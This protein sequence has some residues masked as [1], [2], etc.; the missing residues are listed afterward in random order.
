MKTIT[1]ITI[2][3]VLLSLS[4]DFEQA[5]NFKYRKLETGD[6]LKV[7]GAEPLVTPQLDSLHLSCL[8]K[9]FGENDSGVY[10]STFGRQKLE[11]ETEAHDGI[12]FESDSVTESAGTDGVIKLVEKGVL[13]VDTPLYKIA[14]YFS[15]ILQKKQIVTSPN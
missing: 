8:S 5:T 6:G 11:M 9:T 3:C 12:R 13:N 4:F 1:F 2:L 10:D 7:D 14:K 15:Y